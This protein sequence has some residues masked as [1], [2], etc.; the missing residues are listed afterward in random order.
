MTDIINPPSSSD[1]VG[2]IPN[3][4]TADPI[5]V[6]YFGTGVTER[7]ML[8]DNI[9]WIEVKAFSEGDR[10]RYLNEINKDIR[11]ERQTGAAFLKNT[12][13]QDRY[14]LLKVAITDWY[15]FKKDKNGE[16][17]EHP[18]N[19]HNVRDFLNV[20][21]PKIFEKVELKVRELNPWLMADL[22]VEQMEEQIEELNRLIEI[23]Q[24]EE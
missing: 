23:K 12:A 3:F 5:P 9:Q 18:Y 15:I 2:D 10:R 13:G 17:R 6:D 8:P 22:T 11:V 4:G 24:K 1:E 21:S 19:E 20:G 7:V 14:E 16:M